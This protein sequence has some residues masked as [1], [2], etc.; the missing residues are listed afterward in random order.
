MSL[1]IPWTVDME[2]TG[3]LNVCHFVTYYL[4]VTQNWIYSQ[5]AHNAECRSA[6]LCQRLVNPGQFPFDAVYPICRSRGQLSLPGRLFHKIFERYPLEPHLSTITRVKPDI[7]HGHFL[8]ESWRNYRLIKRLNIP[9]VTTC[10]GQD[11][12]SLLRKPFWAARSRKVFELGAAFIVEGEY[13]GETLAARGCQ[14]EK[15]QVI[16]LGVDAERICRIDGNINNRIDSI[17]NTGDGDKKIR[18]LFTGLNR[19]KKGA[20]YAAEAFVK[21]LSIHTNSHSNQSG[22]GIDL[23]L[24]LLGDGVYRGRIEKILADAGVRQKAVFHGVTPYSRY[25]EILKGADI[26]LAPSVHAAD[27]D[28]EGGAPVVVIEAL[29]AGV[30]VIGSNHCDI[31]NIVSNGSTGLLSAER[32]VEALSRDIVTLAENPRLRAAMGERGAKYARV[33][34]DISRQVQKITGVYREVLTAFAGG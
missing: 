33:E 24:H 27:G 19:E 4:P 29:C 20:L 6:V 12:T 10:Y 32:D 18:V 13:M 8:L 1:L 22:N 34:H 21:A 17:N 14:K 15:I 28:T 23:E 2:R 30:P 3:D 16:K 7:L 25:L 9:L 26:V 5:L 31:P 11:V